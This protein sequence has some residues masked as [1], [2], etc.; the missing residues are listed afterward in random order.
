MNPVGGDWSDAR[1]A[2][3][4]LLLWARHSIG[5]TSQSSPFFELIASAA[6]CQAPDSFPLCEKVPHV[7]ATLDSYPAIPLLEPAP[8]TGFAPLAVRASRRPG[9][10]GG[11]RHPADS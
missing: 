4:I 10:P 2:V 5:L 7:S 1:T 6:P 8:A 9:R 11:T 3:T